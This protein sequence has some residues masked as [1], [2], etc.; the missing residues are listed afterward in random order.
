MNNLVFK[1]QNNQA[2]PTGNGD[3]SLRDKENDHQQA[4]RHNT[5]N[6]HYEGNR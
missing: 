5:G 1:G 4:R 2:Y 6:D 3:E